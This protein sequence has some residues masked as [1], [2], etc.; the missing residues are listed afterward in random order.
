MLSHDKYTSQIQPNEISQI[1]SSIG[2]QRLIT[3]RY[4]AMSGEYRDRWSTVC[5]R[6][7]ANIHVCS[8]W[9]NNLHNW[10]GENCTSSA[11]IL[12]GVFPCVTITFPYAIDISGEVYL[13][14]HYVIKFVSDLQTGRWFSPG[15]L[16]SS[17]NKTDRHDITEILLKVVL[18][19]I[20][21]TSNTYTI[22][23]YFLTLVRHWYD[24]PSHHRK[25][26]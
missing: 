8:K 17:T 19:T 25:F 3:L 6:L 23:I 7:W 4:M 26:L 13:I 20:T 10:K 24:R 12:F 18:N 21:L 5:Y 2:N 1:S 11:S 14:Q 9:G 16:V 15:T 22:E